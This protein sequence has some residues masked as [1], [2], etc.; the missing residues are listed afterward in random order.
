MDYN[1]HEDQC[2]RTNEGV[3]ADDG[4]EVGPGQK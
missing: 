3:D 2:F 4:E 1:L